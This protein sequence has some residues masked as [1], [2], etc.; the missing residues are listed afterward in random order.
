M[1]AR[2]PTT[3]DLDFSKIDYFKEYS[4]SE[5][6]HVLAYWQFAHQ[7]LIGAFKLIKLSEY[8]LSQ[9]NDARS[10]E[11]VNALITDTLNLVVDDA[12]KKQCEELGM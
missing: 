6:G 11:E 5:N 4:T 12:I 10:T 8:C 3:T 9:I 1:G 2:A 7:P